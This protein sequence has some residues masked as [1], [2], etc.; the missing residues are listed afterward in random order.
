[1]KHYIETYDRT[2]AQI[3]GNGDGQAVISAKNY[4]ATAAYNRVRYGDVRKFTTRRETLFFRVVNERG[5][6]V[7][8]FFR[9]N[10]D[11]PT[12]EAITA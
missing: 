5:Q 11:L 10:A 3:L 8:K 9:F 6:T 1:M 2:G 7:E 12:V 4:K